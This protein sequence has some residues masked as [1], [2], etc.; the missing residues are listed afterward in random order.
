[1]GQRWRIR[2]RENGRVIHVRKK[3]AELHCVSR[4]DVPEVDRIVLYVDDLDRCPEDRVVDVLQAIHL[5]LALPLFVVVVGVDAR[6]VSR[7][8]EL[9]YQQLW[10]GANREKKGSPGEAASPQDYLEKIFQ[11]PFWLEAMD[12]RSTRRL[13]NSLLPDGSTETTTGISAVRTSPVPPPPDQDSEATVAGRS[14]SQQRVATSRGNPPA[15]GE[16]K[17]ALPED[18]GSEPRN[19]E[20]RGSEPNE[21]KPKDRESNDRAMKD[22]ETE[23]AEPL[24]QNLDLQPHERELMLDL[25][26]VV[27]RSPRAVKRFVNV[28]RLYRA[29]ISDPV[30]LAVLVGTA[31]QPGSFR[32]VLILLAVITGMP[33]AVERIFAEIHKEKADRELGEF[34]SHPGDGLFD[35]GPTSDTRLWNPL[36]SFIKGYVK[37]GAGRGM[38]IGDLQRHLREISR[39]SFRVGRL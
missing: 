14:E 20:P 22:A 24:A 9:R 17:G 36:S 10:N 12:G 2:D 29:R 27:G 1:M 15:N 3:G 38:T 18:H 37:D 35:T 7:S 33:E 4:W 34:V 32:A 5:L 25:S 26:N 19:A 6:W 31:E 11:I 28:Y 39:Y 21:T 23:P 16:S 8:L 30:E 13:L